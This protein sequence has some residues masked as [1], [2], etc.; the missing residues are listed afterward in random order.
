MSRISCSVQ[1]CKHSNN[2]PF[3]C[4]GCIYG[5][6]WKHQVTF[7]QTCYAI[8]V[9]AQCRLLSLSKAYDKSVYTH[10]CTH[11]F[12]HIMYV[13]MTTAV[14]IVTAAAV[15]IVVAITT[16]NTRSDTKNHTTNHQRKYDMTC[17]IIAE[18][19]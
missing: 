19:K 2:S 9:I 18:K 6:S 3:E 14:I 15:I 16:N 4:H 7:I 11:T 17:K 10:V 1:A 12:Y 8:T 5:Y 13:A